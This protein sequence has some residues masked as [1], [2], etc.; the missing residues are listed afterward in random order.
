[1][2]KKV[3]PMLIL[4]ASAS[5]APTLNFNK[6]QSIQRIIDDSEIS[7]TIYRSSYPSSNAVNGFLNLPIFPTLPALRLNGIS[8][9]YLPP[10]GYYN[11]H[12]G[13]LTGHIVGAFPFAYNGYAHGYGWRH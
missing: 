5:T 10:Q 8:P 7:P 1:M 6:L 9:V 2:I 3:F 12:N 4:L 13:Q 11:P